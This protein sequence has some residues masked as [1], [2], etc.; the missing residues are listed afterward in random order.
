M[1]WIASKV[2]V[3]KRVGD[4][5]EKGR[6]R[7]EEIKRDKENRHL[8]NLYRQ[9]HC[10]HS[11]FS[12]TTVWEQQPQ[13]EGDIYLFLAHKEP[14]TPQQALTH[15]HTLYKI[16]PDSV[17]VSIK[18]RTGANLNVSEEQAGSFHKW[19]RE[20]TGEQIRW[21]FRWMLACMRFLHTSING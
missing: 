4:T 7:G 15:T 3:T 21:N 9:L 10:Q 2:R 17:N 11:L 18:H 1:L 16:P 19:G 12:G 5:Q 13:R 6:I 8:F 20:H 14:S